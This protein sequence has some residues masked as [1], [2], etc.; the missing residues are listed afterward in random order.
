VHPSCQTLGAMKPSAALLR[1]ALSVTFAAAAAV[2]S[3]FLAVEITVA[4]YMRSY[5]I[6]Q[7]VDL[8]NDYGFGVLAS[9]VMVGVTLVSGLL[10]FTLAWRMSGKIFGR[11]PETR[12]E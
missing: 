1:V 4:W 5:G 3:A 7:R 8:S 9:A 11:G 6:A 2:G 10:S 12:R